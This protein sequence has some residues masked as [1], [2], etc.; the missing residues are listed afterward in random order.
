MKRFGTVYL[1]TNRVNG[2]SYVGS[3]SM[4]LGR[5]WAC[6]KEAARNGRHSPIAQAIRDFGK[7]AFLVVAIRFGDSRDELDEMESK[8]IISHRSMY[9]NGYNLQTGGLSGYKQ[10]KITVEEI[11]QKNRGRKV[12]KETCEKLRIALK[13]NNKGRI[14]TQAQRDAVGNAHRGKPK[15]PEQRAKMSL[16]AKNASP[17]IRARRVA[18][19]REA[20]AKKK[21]I[22]VYA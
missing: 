22:G 7:D 1:I 3:T 20:I 15:S 13:G 14:P 8:E 6:H 16:A 5:R 10:N 2:M 11:S 18:A 17:E 21:L 12:S 4:T 9:P 19:I